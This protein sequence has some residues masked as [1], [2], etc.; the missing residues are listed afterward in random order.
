MASFAAGQ[1]YFALLAG[2][3]RL[4]H[5]NGNGTIYTVGKDMKQ[6]AKAIVLKSENGRHKS[7]KVAP[8]EGERTYGLNSVKG[9]SLIHSQGYHATPILIVQNPSMPKNTLHTHK[10]FGMGINAATSPESDYGWLLFVQDRS[11]FPGFY[12]WMVTDVFVP[13][14]LIK[15]VLTEVPK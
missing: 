8:K 9:Y 6:T 3:N 13:C 14:G 4:N 5:I 10:I 7:L 11:L 12:S 15:C 1:Q 2:E